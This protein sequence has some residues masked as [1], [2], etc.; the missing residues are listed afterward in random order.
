MLINYSIYADK[1]NYLKRYPNTKLLLGPE[2]APLR[3]E[4]QE[5]PTRITN[6]SVNSVLITTGGTDEL[7]ITSKIINKIM[8]YPEIS[9]LQYHV[10]IGRYNKHLTELNELSEIYPNIKIHNNIKTISALMLECDIAISA[11]GTTLYELC[12]CG[13]PTIVFSIANN[14]LDAVN[15]FGDGYMISAGDMRY[16]LELCLKK[17]F[18]G[19][20]LLKTNYVKRVDFSEKMQTLVTGKG[21]ISIISELY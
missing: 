11:G 3:E 17:I 9:K 20:S 14:Q 10:I 6:K 2:Y 19:I 1:N 21:V 16:D 8:Q 5:L 18:N 12:A 13:L 4:F 7:N 15:G